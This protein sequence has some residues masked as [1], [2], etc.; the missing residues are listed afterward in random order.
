MGI[1][2][3]LVQIYT[4]DGKG[5]TTAALGLCLRAVGQG[6]RACFIQFLKGEWDSGERRAAL[7]LAP[8][9][10]MYSFASARWGDPAHA[11]EGTPWW[12]LP[13]SEEDRRKAE[14]G[15]S[16]ARE[17]V[18]S[19]R[20]DIVVLDEAISAVRLGLLSL[21]DVTD[22]VRTKPAGVELVLT[23]RDAPPELVELADLVSEV[24]AVKH[25][26]TRGI[27]ARRGIEY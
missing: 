5:K 10:E 4:G 14:E 8:E 2:R 13:P 7:R 9:L 15:L 26:Y 22:L 6:L 21:A 18:A 27:G 16:F 20:Y 1:A 25:P 11:P 12:R 17:A 19:G 23:G 24:K 3:G